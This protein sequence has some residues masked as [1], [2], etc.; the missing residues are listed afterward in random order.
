MGYE[1]RMRFEIGL[2]DFAV[3]VL[4]RLW[5]GVNRGLQKL[6]HHRR[7]LSVRTIAQFH[8]VVYQYRRGEQIH[9]PSIG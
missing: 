4:G 9:H 8:F 5:R 3:G 1:P 6:R 7:A 2:A